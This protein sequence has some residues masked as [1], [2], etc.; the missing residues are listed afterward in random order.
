MIF[1]TVFGCLADVIFD[2]L[3]IDSKTYRRL[4]LLC[5]EFPVDVLEKHRRISLFRLHKVPYSFKKL[6]VFCNIKTE[7]LNELLQIQVEKLN[8]SFAPINNDTIRLLTYMKLKKLDISKTII[9]SESYFSMLTVTSL[10]LTK[11]SGITR[12][13]IIA[14]STLPLKKL[15][16]SKCSYLTDYDIDPIENCTSLKH[17]EVMDCYNI[18]DNC[19]LFTLQL[20]Y[21]DIYRCHKIS[22]KSLLFSKELKVL[23]MGYIPNITYRGLC[24]LKKL[25]RLEYVSITG[26]YINKEHLIKVRKELD[27]KVDIFEVYE[28]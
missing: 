11:C 21:I 17:L 5:K 26:L 22:D 1:Y 18:T 4:S 15:K 10:I 2:Y 3:K 8:I 19:K 9:P 24:T 16:L 6:D 12:N 20:E 25:P 27:I 13:T 7:Q 23:I 14:I 28:I